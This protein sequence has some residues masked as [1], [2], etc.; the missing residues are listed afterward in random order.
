MKLLT[1]GKPEKAADHDRTARPVLQQPYLSV[2]DKALYAATPYLAIRLP[3]EIEDGDT[4]GPITADAL[5][6]A[7]K[8]KTDRIKADGAL[9]VFGKDTFTFSRPDNGT[10]P[11]IEQ[12]LQKDEE[13]D[14]SV[15]LNPALL[16][17]L[18][19]AMDAKIVRLTFSKKDPAGRVIRVEPVTFDKTA[20]E[21]V[22]KD[23][24]VGALMPARLP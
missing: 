20:V 4:D 12:V 11:N 18:A 6:S 14:F 13:S 24:I 10:F 15:A 8:Q 16:T 3:V 17:A 19:E 1:P 21:K 7:R 9:T 22:V 23:R 5:A 2:K